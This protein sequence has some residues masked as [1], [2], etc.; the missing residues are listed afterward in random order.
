MNS[1]Q[2]EVKLRPIEIQDAPVLMELNNS[3]QIA[4]F[5]VGNPTQVNLEQQ[6][7]W[8]QGLDREKTTKRW[9][10]CLGEQAVGTVF[11]SSIDLNNGVGNANIKLLP[12]FQGRGIAK[13]AIALLCDL[14]FDELG[15]FCVTANVLSYNIKSKMLFEK[16][17][18]H[19]D[20][21]LRSRV[22]KNGVRQDLIALS[23]LK[24][25]HHG[26]NS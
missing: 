13:R 24:E 5:V 3:K 19:V 7:S 14:A 12:T 4:D 21:I 10:I 9:T 22:L 16:C 23:L 17:G 25:E 26:E 2:L 1:L 20:G 6:I 11:L 18:F 8:I 15:L